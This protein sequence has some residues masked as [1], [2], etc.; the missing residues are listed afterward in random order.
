MSGAHPFRFAVQ[1]S[2]AATPAAWRERAR[3]VEGLGYSTLYV[4]DHLG[5]QW[6]PLVAMAV[7]AEATR[8]LRIG[9][10][11]LANDFRHPVIL[12]KEAATLD[13]VSEGRLELGLGAGWLPSD[14]DDSG[15]VFD[16]AGVRIDRL[17]EAVTVMRQMWTEGHAS[18]EGA[19]YAVP[20]APGAPD[21]YRSG[22]PTLVLGGG[23]RR[24]LS[25]AAREADIVSV[26]PSLAA[27]EI[28]R[29]TAAESL[30]DRY[31]QRVKWLR[32]AAGS[33]FD[34]L[35]LQCPA[36]VAQVTADRRAALEESA[37]AFS[38]DPDDMAETPLAVVGT[39]AEICESLQRRREEFGF[40]YVV[41]W[42]H[43]ADAFAP[44]VAALAGT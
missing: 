12:A 29:D 38:L 19:H 31:R 25:L 22:G 5:A 7:A 6:G 4:T 2:G 1:A 34:S 15:F 20:N 35:E 33:R 37:A 36:W 39:V 14:Y 28:G 13:L 17:A 21:P 32:E 3:A 26:I 9:S 42:D 18:F 11:V 40:S 41:I 24:I 27:G 43:E 10:L 16:S 8:T 23:G 30:V 44:V